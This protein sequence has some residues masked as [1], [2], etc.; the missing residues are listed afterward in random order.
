V[1]GAL[2]VSDEIPIFPTS[3]DTMSE[4][5][6]TWLRSGRCRATRLGGALMLTATLLLAAGCGNRGNRVAG[7]VTLN[8]T[9]VKGG[10]VAFHGEGQ[11]QKVANI[12]A[13]GEYAIDDP[14]AGTVAVT[15]RSL[16]TNLPMGSMPPPQGNAKLLP[17]P[18]AV[19][20]L[21][22]KYELPNNGLTFTNTGGTQKFD[23]ELTP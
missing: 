12:N 11:K 15:V 3:E 22:R 2:G 7:K 20:A 6:S 1:S 21:P 10:L 5:F 9:P 14:P 13:D 19:E 23:I 16:P 8:G 4:L 18:T 17:T